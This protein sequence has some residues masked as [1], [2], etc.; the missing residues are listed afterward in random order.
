MKTCT[1]T[2]IM[3]CYTTPRQA[4]GQATD[5]SELERKK[6]ARQEELA[7]K[8]AAAAGVVKAAKDPVMQLEGKM[9]KVENQ[10]GS[11]LDR[12][13]DKL[14]DV[15]MSQSVTISD[16]ENYLLEITGKVNMVI[17]QDCK[18]VGVM[19]QDVVSGVEVSKGIKVE[20]QASG[21]LPSFN[22]D[23]C[24]EL[25]LYTTEKSRDVEITSTA[26]VCVNVTFT[27]EKV[28]HT[29]HHHHYSPSTHSPIREL[30]L[31]KPLVAMF[32]SHNSEHKI[33][34]LSSYSVMCT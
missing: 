27:D 26:S 1:S 16:C 20:V 29:S 4:L 25:M 19:L 12:K 3:S 9:W 22:I 32:S 14:E 21:V 31:S 15:N 34:M 13:H 30:S 8:K 24:N 33:L 6:A 5:F 2:Q 18:N 17:I 10:M 23:R 11:K 7:K 28:Y